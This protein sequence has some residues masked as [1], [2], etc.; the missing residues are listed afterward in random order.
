MEPLPPG[1]LGEEVQQKLHCC[2]GRLSRPTTGP[3]HGTAGVAR[4]AQGVR[5]CLATERAGRVQESF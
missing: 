2:W 1:L 4:E 5:L 3:E